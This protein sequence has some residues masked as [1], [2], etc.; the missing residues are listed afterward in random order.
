M[1]KIKN[2]SV[3]NKDRIV[4]VTVTGAQVLLST[5]QI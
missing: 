3:N 4:C 1:K 5:L 2:S